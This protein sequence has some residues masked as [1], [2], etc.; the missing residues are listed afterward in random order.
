V[1]GTFVVI[2]DHEQVVSTLASNMLAGGC[3]REVLPHEVFRLDFDTILA[4]GKRQEQMD[5]SNQGE[6]NLVKDIHTYYSNQIMPLIVQ[7]DWI[8]EAA[9]KLAADHVDT[10]YQCIR[11]SS[12]EAFEVQ[13]GLHK[14]NRE[15]SDFLQA[16]SP[17]ALLGKT[18][19]LTKTSDFMTII[20]FDK[21]SRQAQAEATRL[22]EW[23]KDHETM[24]LTVTLRN[25]RDSY[26]MGL[27]RVMF[28]VRRAMKAKYGRHPK[29]TDD[30][31]LEPACYIDWF[32]SLASNQHPFYPILGDQKLAEFY[33][34][35]RNVASHH[36]G[37]KWEPKTDQV[38]L[39]DRNTTLTVRVKE[40][41]QRYRYLVYLCDYGLRAI[42]S[43]FCE[44]EKGTVSDNLLDEY[45]KTF[46]KDFSSCEEARVRHYT[47]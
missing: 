16:H 30:K 40:F 45:N 5:P 37:L 11:L 9:S 8:F 6:Y 46:P 33:K 28:V 27:P 29:S 2:H 19:S 43:A 15:V 42:L 47:R 17:K 13:T 18:V 39:K 4:E 32:Q 1:Q 41:Q 21:L 35:A 20:E 12:E 36:K 26:E 14:L 24:Q 31:L 25:I 34:V 10:Y 3:M 38:I 7:N 23:A 22:L 44:R